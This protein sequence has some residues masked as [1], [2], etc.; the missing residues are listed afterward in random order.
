MAVPE[1]DAPGVPE[2]V[3]TYGDMMSLLLT[4]FIMLVSMS[5]LKGDSGSTRA[6]LDAIREVFGATEGKMSSPGRSNQTTSV[7]TDLDSDSAK[8]QKGTKKGNQNSKG[9]GGPN[10]SVK[11]LSFQTQI[12]LGGGAQFSRFDAS[13]SLEMK[14]SLDIIAEVLKKKLQQIVVRGHASPVPMP[15]SADY[16]AVSLGSLYGS[17]TYGKEN[18]FRNRDQ[19]EIQDKM[20]LSFARARSVMEYLVSKGIPRVR[21]LVSAAGSSELMQKTRD[22]TEQEFNRRV[23]VFVIDSYITSPKN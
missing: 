15:S 9:S 18:N 23:D 19:F 17:W 3:V 14:K 20:D 16:A 2:W 6:A 4:F 5:E 7:L 22:R 21:L 11:R 12:T 10:K 1:D 13:L 8:M